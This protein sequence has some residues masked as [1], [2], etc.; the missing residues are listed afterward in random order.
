MMEREGEIGMNPEIATLHDRMSQGGDWRTF[1]QEIDR[2]HKESRTQDEYVTLLEAH[3]NLVAVAEHCFSPETCA[4]VRRIAA[5]EY[6]TFLLAEAM[7]GELVN[8]VVLDRITAREVEAGRLAPDDD[9]RQL[10]SAGGSVIGDPADMR[11]DRK[12]GDRIG[13]IGALVGLA[14]IF[15][16]GGAVGGVVIVASIGLGWWIN[17]GRKK[18]ALGRARDDRAARGYE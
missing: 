9:L 11:Y 1:Q 6:K 7:E 10:A 12:L 18:Q 17:E 13:L 14:L 2:L 4:E 8:P 16:V 5:S 3:R 15:L